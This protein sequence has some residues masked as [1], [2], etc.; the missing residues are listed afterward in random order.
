MLYVPFTTFICA[1][2]LLFF[3]GH[4]DVN[5]SCCSIRVVTLLEELVLFCFF[6]EQHIIHN[7]KSAIPLNGAALLFGLNP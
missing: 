2:S 4:G 6:L 3:L 5:L 7:V 1:L